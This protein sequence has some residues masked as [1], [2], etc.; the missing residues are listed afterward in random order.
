M[1]DPTS[2]SEQLTDS[3]WLSELAEI[4]TSR[5]FF[6]RL[7]PRHNAIHLQGSDETLLVGFDTIAT[8]RAGSASGIPHTMLLAEIH[9]WSHLSLLAHQSTWFREA[10]VYSFVDRLTDDG[11]FESY[12]RVIFY[13]AGSCGYAAAAFSVAAPGSTVVLVSPQATLDP[14]LA[15]WDDRFAK[16]RR[17]D[18]RRRY[19]F[20]PDMIEAADR[21][22]LFY[23]PVEELDAMH[24]ALF[25]GPQV[26]K[27]RV[28]HGGAQ[29]GRDLQEM[30]V[31]SDVIAAAGQGR[32]NEIGIY[33]ALRRRHDFMPY[34]RNLLNRVHIE[35]RQLLVGLLCR[36]V[37][38][39]R[40]A[41]RFRHH[42]DLAE[43][44][45]AEDGKTLPPQY[46]KPS[47]ASLLP[48]LRKV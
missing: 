43:R 23:D 17:T 11:F 8:A 3:E 10:P 48:E 34:L 13:G 35:E 12:D 33:R 31:I 4:G 20:A 15:S 38:S 26:T 30:K 25:R 7:G 32:L 36:A 24:A 41:P 2:L 47:A 37:T 27:I 14:E 46:R 18:F 42:L 22:V 45:L 39:R 29:L 40:N 9:G 19:G 28:R 6:R 44:S 1:S 21:V 16:M 5:G